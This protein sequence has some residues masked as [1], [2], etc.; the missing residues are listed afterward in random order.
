MKFIL[1]FLLLPLSSEV[2]STKNQHITKPTVLENLTNHSQQ[3]LP[4][5]AYVTNTQIKPALQ[6][7]V[8][9][10]AVEDITN[11]LVSEKLDGVRGYWD[12]S[13]L[14]SR[15]GKPIMS[16][17]WFTRHWPSQAMDG[18]LWIARGYFQPLLSCVT[19]HKPNENKA[20]SCW[21]KVSFKVFDLTHSAGTFTQRFSRIKQFV[22]AS[23]SP[24]LSFI[25]QHKI[26]T[27]AALENTVSAVIN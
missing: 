25:K 1:Y 6:H 23:M 14:Y 22:T 26:T 3:V 11:Y 16:P 15:Q 12:G 10:R 5:S 18:E 21:R 7:G 19:K 17:E 2:M 13:E 27:I 24:Y 4:K 20:S 8:N 9:Y